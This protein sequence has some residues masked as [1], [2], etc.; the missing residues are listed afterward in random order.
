MAEV[1]GP[2][3]IEKLEYVRDV[4]A[5]KQNA[6]LLTTTGGEQFGFPMTEDEL[7]VQ[8][9]RLKSALEIS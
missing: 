6:L 2:Y 1:N 5:L 3:F 9:E 8:I 7:R 4:T